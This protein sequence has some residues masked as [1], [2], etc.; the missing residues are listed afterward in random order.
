MW[1]LVRSPLCRLPFC[2]KVKHPPIVPA[3]PSPTIPIECPITG[4]PSWFIRSVKKK[5][6]RPLPTEAWTS[7][8]GEILLR[9]NGPEHVSKWPPWFLPPNSWSQ[10]WIEVECSPFS[11]GRSAQ[12]ACPTIIVHVDPM[13]CANQSSHM[14]SKVVD[15]YGSELSRYFSKL[16]SSSDS[17]SSSWK[18]Q[19]YSLWSRQDAS[20]KLLRIMHN[21]II[22]RSWGVQLKCKDGKSYGER[23]KGKVCGLH[24]KGGC[25]SEYRIDIIYIPLSQQILVYDIQK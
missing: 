16:I 22:H 25:H 12:K 13:A 2:V 24:P 21:D 19:T 20:V 1:Y 23:K 17:I 6:R 10:S 8:E 5:W 9:L 14:L 11:V 3:F 7:P 18:Y 15:R 4:S